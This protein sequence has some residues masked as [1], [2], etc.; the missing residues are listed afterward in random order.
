TEEVENINELKNTLFH[1]FDVTEMHHLEKIKVL[2]KDSKNTLYVGSA[3]LAEVIFKKDIPPVLSVIGSISETSLNQIDYASNNSFNVI[4][5]KINDLISGNVEKYISETIE[6]LNNGNDTIITATRAKNDYKATVDSFIQL[7]VEDRSEISNI[8]KGRITEI[9]KKVLTN[10]KVSG[11]FLTGG[12]TAISM[13]EQLGA[14][15][16]RI[17]AEILPG[18]VKSFLIKGPFNGLPI[19]TKAGAFG[20]ETTVVKSSKLLKGEY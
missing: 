5:I 17:E 9:S 2:T 15:G 4:T 13:I 12:D 14:K 16:C 3:G 6:S 20:D 1:I 11:V 19:V 7:G 8:V 10:T 18:V